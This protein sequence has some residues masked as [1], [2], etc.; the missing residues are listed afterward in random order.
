ME[1]VVN[2]EDVKPWP[3]GDSHVTLL[4]HAIAKAGI[5]MSSLK[6][7]NF[8]ISEHK[9][10]VTVPTAVVTD[11]YLDEHQT[12]VLD[13]ST[14]LFRLAD[15][16]LEQNARRQAV[17]D[18]RRAALRGGIA[19]DAQDRAKSELTWFFHQIGYAKVEINFK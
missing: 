14:G 2:L 17:D 5:D 8:D 6:A 11:V 9:I 16:D 3:G 15:K 1:K 18:I 10:I 19:K 7:S 13:R 4:A 12:Q